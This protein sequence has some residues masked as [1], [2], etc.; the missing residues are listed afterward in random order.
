MTFDLDAAR[1]L[2]DRNP[3][4]PGTCATC[5]DSMAYAASWPCPTATALGATGRSEWTGPTDPIVAAMEAAMHPDIAATGMLII[6]KTI[7]YD[8][9]TERVTPDGTVHPTSRRC[10]ALPEGTGYRASGDWRNIDGKWV[11]R[12]IEIIAP[13]SLPGFTPGWWP[14]EKPTNDKDTE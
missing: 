1:A 3:D 5:R 9:N 2:H 8:P 6:P 11:L 13:H 12:A 4:D 14:G 10:C 7:E